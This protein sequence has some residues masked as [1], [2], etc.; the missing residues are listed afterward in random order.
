MID[1]IGYAAGFIAMI[2]FL[3]QLLKT[4]RTKKTADISMIMLLLTLAANIL[5]VVYG[6]L[7][8]LYPVVI[9]LGIMTCILIL[10]IALTMKYRGST[11]RAHK[12]DSDG[13]I[14]RL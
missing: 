10:Q 12:P 11:N 9:M 3:P 14:E 2:T 6:I 13:T 8:E 7:L 5:Y 4:I 1:T